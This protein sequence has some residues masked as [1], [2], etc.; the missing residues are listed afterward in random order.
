MFTWLHPSKEKMK[1][2]TVFFTILQLKSL[3]VENFYELF[4]DNTISPNTM[5]PWFLAF[6]SFEE[7]QNNSIQD[8]K[9]C[10]ENQLNKDMLSWTFVPQVYQFR[11]Y[12]GGA[13]FFNEDTDNWEAGGVSVSNLT[14]Q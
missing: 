3:F 7:S 4:I 5:G 9:K 6:T 10:Q 13:Y 8:G 11:I 2:I 14:S 1:V 12:V